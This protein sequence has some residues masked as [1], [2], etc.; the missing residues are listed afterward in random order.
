MPR[1]RRR[2]GTIV[3]KRPVGKHWW[4]EAVEDPKMTGHKKLE[5]RSIEQI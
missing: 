5:K 2:Y 3:V 4:I 1:R